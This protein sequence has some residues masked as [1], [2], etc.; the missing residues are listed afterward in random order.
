[1]AGTEVAINNNNTERVNSPVF[2]IFHKFIYVLAGICYVSYLIYLVIQLATEYPV[3]I[4]KY[5]FVNNIDVPNME[6]CSPGFFEILRCDTKLNNSTNIQN[7]CQKYISGPN[8]NITKGADDKYC[9]Y[10]FKA[11]KTIEYAHEKPDGLN[12]LKLFYMINA[13]DAEKDKVGLALIQIRVSS[14][15]LLD[16]SDMDKAVRSR[17]KLQWN[18]MPGIIGYVSLVGFLHIIIDRFPVI[19]INYSLT[20]LLDQVQDNQFPFNQNPSSVPNGTNGYFSVAAGD[21]VQEEISERRT[22]TILSSIASAGGG[23]GIIGA[24]LVWLYGSS[25]L[26]EWGFARGMVVDPLY[27]VDNLERGRESL[28]RYWKSLEAW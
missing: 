27:W 15:D 6:I 10:T 16:V 24:I 2:K 28:K 13:T 14:P 11:N 22:S 4:T 25:S 3:V 9:C 17:I 21:F 1:M 18:F 20:L 5:N 7:G 12:K 23:L 19:H 8:I 26:D